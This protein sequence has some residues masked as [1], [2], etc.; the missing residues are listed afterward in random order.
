MQYNS[1]LAIPRLKQ[2]M[3]RIKSAKMIFIFNC[4]S[5]FSNS[6]ITWVRY[7][8]VPQLFVS[9]EKALFLFVKSIEPPEGF[10][11]NSIYAKHR[12][13]LM[14]AIELGDPG[15]ETLS[16]L[17]W[18]H[19]EFVLRHPSILSHILSVAC[20][21]DGYLSQVDKQP[22]KKFAYMFMFMF[23]LC[24]TLLET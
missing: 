14:S 12:P 20:Q 2:N 11:W 19:D 10:G 18:H 3:R 17:T 7:L 8:L 6:V 15:W 1:H 5:G 23:M 22:K 21:D 16:G 9:S 13:L 4:Y 24:H